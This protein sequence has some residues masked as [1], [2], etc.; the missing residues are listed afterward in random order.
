MGCNILPPNFIAFGCVKKKG[1][2]K[3]EGMKRRCKN[4]ESKWEEQKE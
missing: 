2:C 3:K 1:V 4:K